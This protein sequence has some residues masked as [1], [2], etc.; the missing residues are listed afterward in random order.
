MRISVY[1]SDILRVRIGND[2]KRLGSI[3]NYIDKYVHEI[4]NR[5]VLKESL[6]TQKN[7]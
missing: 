2:K 6:L 1:I 5:D 3:D 7:T 4:K